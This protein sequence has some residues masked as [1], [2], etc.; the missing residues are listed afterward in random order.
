MSIGVSLS[1]VS[2]RG[3]LLVLVG[4]P[5]NDAVTVTIPYGIDVLLY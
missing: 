1:G 5:S 3:A 2:Q 4:Q